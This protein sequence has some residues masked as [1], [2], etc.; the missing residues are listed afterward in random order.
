VFLSKLK[1][2]SC[3]KVY[4]VKESVPLHTME[5]LEVRRGIASAVLY[6]RGKEDPRSSLDTS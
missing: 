3:L 5:V 2:I 1:L 4:E 6:P